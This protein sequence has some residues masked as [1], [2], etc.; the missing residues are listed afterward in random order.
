MRG[1]NRGRCFASKIFATAIGLS[2]SAVRP[3]TVSVGSAT[4]SPFRKSCS[5]RSVAAVCD[6]RRRSWVAATIS[7]FTLALALRAPCRFVSCEKLRDS[8]ESSYQKARES[9]PQEARHFLRQL[10]RLQVYPPG[11][12]LAFVLLKEAN[13]APAALMMELAHPKPGDESAQPR[14]PPGAQRF[15]PPG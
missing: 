1:S 4:I 8:C 9:R 7:V 11:Y 3:Y 10:S 5:A 15:P 6:R 2:A 13:R 14:L 12:R